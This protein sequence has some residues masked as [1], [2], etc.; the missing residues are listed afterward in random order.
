MIQGMPVTWLVAEALILVLFV[1][2]MIHASRQEDATIKIMELFG[3]LI[4]AAIFEHMGVQGGRYTYD[5]HR[6]MLI[7]K[8]PLEVILLEAVIFY[9]ALRLTE[10]LKIPSWGKPFVVGLFASLQDVTIDPAAAH[11][12]YLYEGAM[13]GQWNW[14]L[15]Y[16]G[17]FVGIPFYNFSGWYY[18]AVCYAFA[19]QI[20]RWLC[21]KYKHQSMLVLHPFLTA[22]IATSFLPIAGLMICGSPLFPLPHYLPS[23]ELALW[24]INYLLG[25]AILLKFQNIDKPFDLKNNLPVFLVPVALHLYD[26]A[27]VLARDIRVAL[28]PVMLV[29]AVH[30]V[31]LCCVCFKG[32]ALLDPVLNRAQRL[33]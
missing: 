1:M 33:R 16:A 23:V 19:I 9:T 30:I 13:S 22:I 5:L 12:R 4:F 18:F 2:C 27:V 15:D 14:K 21:K 20:M 10:Y 6:V 31:Y 25:L 32:N 3:F 29:G 11:D 28:L 24:A 8:V 7:G 17:G 26:I